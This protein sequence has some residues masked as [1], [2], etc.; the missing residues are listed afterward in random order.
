MRG[1]SAFLCYKKNLFNTDNLGS[2]VKK[3]VLLSILLLTVVFM[4]AQTVPGQIVC[5]Q[6]ASTQQYIGSPSLVIL[7]NGDYVASHD[8][9]GPQ[10]SEWQQAVTTVYRSKN[11]GKS[12]KKVSTIQ[13]A[14]WSSLFV[15]KGDLYLLGP[16][17]HHGTV[18]IR[19]ST[20][21]GKTWTQPT[22][23][24]N[25]VILT[26]EFHCAPMPVVEHNGR[27]WRP[28][29]TAHGPI[30]QWGKRYGAMVMSASVDD[31]LLDAKSWR[32]SESLL[33]DSTYLNG[34]FTG[35]LEGN[36]VVDKDGQ[37]WD[38]LRVDDKTSF[39]EKAAMV[40]IS[41][42]GKKLSFDPETGFI[43]FDGGSKKFVIKY[44]STSN[45]YYTLANS[46]PE[47]YRQQYPKRNPSSFRNVLTLRKS[48]DLIHWED[49]RVILEHEDVLKHGFQYVD[50]LFEGDDM[51]VLCRTAY[52]DGKERAHNN[53]DA[54]F[55]TFHRIEGFRDL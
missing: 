31:D 19:K 28:M 10:S 32:T 1:I 52:N 39:K 7:P 33:Y 42:E 3:G 29:E 25:G 41:D 17:R 5:H 23:K 55:L 20:N 18:L 13:G 37:M 50:W 45:Y 16:D 40:K 51:L 4:Q 8:F 44:D 36:F 47:K 34:N 24:E 35:W 15:H 54:N 21:G 2:D 26:G 22:N 38:M 46:I 9:F 12:W 48:K 53:H 43:P 49:V 14:F 11:K 27:L 30:L 6:P